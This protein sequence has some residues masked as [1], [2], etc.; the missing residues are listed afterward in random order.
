MRN[1]DVVEVLNERDEVQADISTEED[2]S[3][4]VS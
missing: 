4:E 2:I 3:H 1:A